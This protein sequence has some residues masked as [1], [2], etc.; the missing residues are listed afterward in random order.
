MWQCL[1]RDLVAAVKKAATGSKWPVAGLFAESENGVAAPV[2]R[3]HPFWKRKYT[4][5]GKEARR[6][7]KSLARQLEEW[8]LPRIRHYRRLLPAA[9]AASLEEGLPTQPTKRLRWLWDQ[10][11][12]ITR[13]AES[14][15]TEGLLR[16]FVPTLDSI[17]LKLA[18][19]YR[20]EPREI[21]TLL[22]WNLRLE[23]L[24]CLLRGIEIEYTISDTC[25]TDRQLT[26]LTIHRVRHIDNSQETVIFFGLDSRWAVNENFQKR[27]TLELESPYRILTPKGLNYTVPTALYGLD[28]SRPTYPLY[29]FI[30]QQGNRREDNFVYRN[31]VDLTFAPKFSAEVLTP[32]VRAHPGAQVVLRLQ[33]NSRDGVR[34]TLHVDHERI[35]GTP[36]VFH[37]P[38]KGE[39]EIDTL[40]LQ[41][42]ADL[43]EGDYR[44]PVRSAD[45][46][47]AHFAV[48]NFAVQFDSTRRVGVVAA[49]RPSPLL[50]AL[51]NLGVSPR[52]LRSPRDLPQVDVAIIEERAL[53]FLKQWQQAGK[54]LREFA[55]R[56][57]RVICL[58]QDAAV[59]KRAALLPGLQ[60][61]PDAHGA[62]NQLPQ[63]TVA[64]PLLQT[65]NPLAET[66][67]KGWLFALSRNRLKRK[68]TDAGWQ[69]V[70]VDE[71]SAP[72]VVERRE[73]SGSVLYVNLALAPQ[74]LNVHPG[75]LRLLA[76]LISY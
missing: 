31:R 46:V 55:A 26:Y 42:P 34:D 32:I 48:R 71:R 60:L 39:V 21:R 45:F 27:F 50:F 49:H 52:L 44:V 54:A 10:I 36:K 68:G 33:N 8:R 30:L 63:A 24:R 66:D 2:D 69:P 40:Q 56:G 53:T 73:G 4:E 72:L 29:F 58:S 51:K 23:K 28:D 16:H 70:L 19:R 12:F 65:P 5:I 22:R 41:F 62:P 7:Y 67:W 25:L 57:G 74:F 1:R 76:N 43:P 37:L 61:Q 15:H 9:R 17:N 11:Q 35:S 18:Q 47:V 38:G 3:K 6:Y 14:G 75:A 59:W 20:L 64:H 13:E